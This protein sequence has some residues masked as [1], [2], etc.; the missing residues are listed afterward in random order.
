M[1]TN[2]LVAV[3]DEGFACDSY[4]ECSDT[5]CDCYYG[6]DNYNFTAVRCSA[7]FCCC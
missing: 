6:V 7:A 5:T 1:D 4:Q 2:H 3:G